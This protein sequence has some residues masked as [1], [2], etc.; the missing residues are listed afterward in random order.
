VPTAKDL[1]GPRSP[2]AGAL[3]G[4]APRPEQ[5]SMAEAVEGA[6]SEGRH[7]VVEA[8]TGVGKSFAYLVPALLHLG[9]PGGPVVVATRTIALQEQ[10]VSKD[11]PLLLNVLGMRDVKVALAKGRG[12]YVCRRRTEMASEEAR[13]LFEDAAKVAETGR[14]REWAEASTDGSLA[15][16]PFRPSSEV[17]DACRAESGNC[18]HRQCPFYEGCAYQRSRRDMYGARLIVANHALVFADLSLREAGVKLLPDYECI[19]LD[20]A[21]AI[22]DDAAEH[23]GARVSPFGIARLLGRFMGARRRTGLFGRAEVSPDLYDGV[24]EARGALRKLFEGVD[25]FRAGENEKRIR[26]AGAFEEPLTEPLAKLLGKLRER[27]GSIEDPG[28]ALEWKSR[29]DRLE[30]DMHAIRLVHGLLDKDLVYWAES[31]GRGGHSVLRAAP[32]DVAPILKRTLFSRVPCVVMTSATLQVA[33][34]FEH[35]RRRV[36]LEEPDEL[37]LG[38]PFDFKRQCKLRLY[39][40]M[41]DPRDPAHDDALAAEVK[42]LVLESKGGAFVLFT[43]YGSLDRTHK[44]VAKDLEKAGLHV[45]RQ[46]G[47]QRTSDIVAAFRER[48][49]CVLFATDT[50]W[51]G[52]DVRGRNLRMVIITRLPFAV[53]DHPLQQARLERI[54]EEGGDPFKQY[55]L[56]QAVLKLR[57]GFGRLIRAH[58][59]EGTVAILD[60]RIVT[61]AYGRTFLSSLPGVGVVT[62]TDC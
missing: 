18:L 47:D 1:L 22:E 3:K 52:I 15:D 14:I 41:P 45:L 16:L 39:P 11:I 28:L 56:P 9:G 37:A 59:D 31:G 49:D 32:A 7:L 53:P 40:A 13:G 35:F 30:E 36:G 42:R 4:F 8:G 29:T 57:Q 55:S 6:L 34:S 60:P 46:G 10:L 25:G 23:F 44:A 20:E 38:S 33:G 43:S 27:H 12:N 58:D 24:E 2:V 62:V 61:K 54:E 5:L 26:G 48:G 21:H 51:Q 19:V 17:W 50:F